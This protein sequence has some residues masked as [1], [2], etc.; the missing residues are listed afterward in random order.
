MKNKNQ[1]QADDNFI[2]QKIAEAF[3]YG[4][5]QLA[6]EL[7]RAVAA[8]KEQP[9]TAPEGEL[10]RI[11]NR[12][13]RKSAAKHR[14]SRMKKMVKMLIA[15]AVLGVMMVG[16]SSW[17]GAKRYYTYEERDKENL[18]DTVVFNNNENILI[19]DSGAES[20]YREIAE[21]L[22]IDVLELSYLPEGMSFNSITETKK[23]YILE[24]EDGTGKLFF[25]QGWHDKPNSLSYVS[26]IK[27]SHIVY[28][29]Y[30]NKELFVYEYKLEDGGV[31]YSVRIKEEDQ[32][33][34]LEGIDVKDFDEIVRGIKP[35]E[36]K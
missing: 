14:K 31:Q 2:D 32:Y 3:G 30:L 8:A 29:S 16:G 33:Y 26:D 13:D 7:D 9:P 4:D 10:Q 15:A 12:L 25:D 18:P 1:M 24:F 19:D 34:F 23:R 20:A 36:N 22:N 11:I 5:Q 21:E 27:K 35:Y 28:N 17:V 6:E